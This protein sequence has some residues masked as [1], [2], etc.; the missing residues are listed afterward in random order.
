MSD[1]VSRTL[2]VHQEHELLQALEKAGL[3]REDAQAVI[4]SSDNQLAQK[5]VTFIRSGGSYLTVTPTEDEERAIAILGE[6]KVITASEVAQ[7]WD[8]GLPE[9]P[10]VPF[11]EETL[12]QCAAENVAGQADW[13]LVYAFGSSLRQQ[14]ELRGTNR[15]SQPCFYSNTW[16]L[17][18]SED[19][20]AAKRVEAGY[21]LLN[22]KL[23]FTNLNWEEQKQAIA[24][25]GRDYKRAEE[26][27]VAETILLIFMVTGERLLETTYH[28]GHSRYSGG[29]RVVVG[30]FDS[31]GFSVD[32]CWPDFY[33]SSIGV[34]LARK[35]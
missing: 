1:I 5:M 13:R 21:R 3:S 34:V 11:S 16:W 19:S 22:F 23:Q 33:G 28:W 20:W 14:R 26:Q 12:R 29:R 31:D 15:S 4:Q 25:L 35:S 24:K 2:S 30:Y 9:V 7:K 27:A 18:K 8:M 6:A 32:Y 10:S 17:E